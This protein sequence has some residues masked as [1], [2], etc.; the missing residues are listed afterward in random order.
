MAKILEV[1]SV[2]IPA[3]SSGVLNFPKKECAKIMISR[4]AQ[5]FAYQK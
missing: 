3:I 5:W 4:V 2:S 1:S